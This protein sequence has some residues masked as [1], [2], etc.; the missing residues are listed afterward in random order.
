MTWTTHS[1][2]PILLRH[3]HCTH[4][5]PTHPASRTH[6]APPSHHTPMS[7]R[8]TSNRKHP[9]ETHRYPEILRILSHCPHPLHPHD[10]TTRSRNHQSLHLTPSQLHQTRQLKKNSPT[11]CQPTPTT[12][13]HTHPQHSQPTP[14]RHH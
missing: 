7:H 4:D 9:L 2:L 14:D 8:N 1:S 13:Q 10:A 11:H 3:N 6:H 5:I 12:T